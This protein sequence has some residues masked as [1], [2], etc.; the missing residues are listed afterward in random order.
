[1]AFAQKGIFT[2]RQYLYKKQ[3]NSILQKSIVKMH[4]FPVKPN[5]VID[6]RG[7]R[8]LMSRQ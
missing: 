1:M 7:Y 4:I 8:I 3:S 5:R 6:L 2:R